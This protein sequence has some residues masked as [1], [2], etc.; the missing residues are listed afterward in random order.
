MDRTMV[1]EWKEP[2]PMDTGAPE[3]VV[4]IIG[5]DLWLA[6]R[7]HDP[8]FPGWDDPSVL[9]NLDSTN[10]NEAFG[11]IRLEGVS[12]YT[13]GPPNDERLHEHPLYQHGLSFYGF[14]KVHLS[15]GRDRWIF[16]FHDETFEA[17]ARDAT[18]L[19]RAIL[20]ATAEVAIDIAIKDGI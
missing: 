15:N 9:A 13:L 8:L 4:R 18:S 10:G 7:A 2:P 6:Y 16:T 1:V 14:Y 5:D 17:V 11:I 3:P 20:A 12:E 19:P